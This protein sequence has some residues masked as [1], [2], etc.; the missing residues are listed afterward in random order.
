MYNRAETVVNIQKLYILLNIQKFYVVQACEGIDAFYHIVYAELLDMCAL[1]K[2]KNVHNLTVA[3]NKVLETL[4]N[5]YD[6]V[7]KSADKGGGIVVQNRTNY[8]LKHL[9][10]CPIPILT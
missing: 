3:E 6:L 10:F 9:D 8:V 1:A 2:N 5:N 7:I 4:T